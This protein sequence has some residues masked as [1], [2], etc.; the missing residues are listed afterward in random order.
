MKKLSAL[1]LCI[2]LA[3]SLIACGSDKTDSSA[4]AEAG[5]PAIVKYIESLP[6]SVYDNAEANNMKLKL[7]AR[8]NSIVEIYTYTVDVAPNAS[9]LLEKAI[10]GAKSQ[11]E[12]EVD[13]LQQECPEIESKIV[14]Y[15][16]KDG[17][18]LATAEFF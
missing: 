18:L 10:E 14:E 8:G 5:N 15:F 3:C 13:V 12:A 9:E 1:L 7:E 17:N 16:D 6:D 4:P 11:F 2:V